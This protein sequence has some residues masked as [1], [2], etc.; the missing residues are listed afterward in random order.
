MIYTVVPLGNP[1]K[2]YEHTRH[3]AA[4]VVL[5]NIADDVRSIDTCEI[6]VP[7]TFMNESGKAIS[8]YLRYHEDRELVVVYDDKD[9]A[10][11]KIRI[12]YDRGD[13]GHNGVRNIIESLGKKD[14]IRIRIGI[15]PVKEDGTVETPHGEIVQKYVLSQ[16]SPDDMNSLRAV[17]SNVLG[18]LKTIA[19]EG[20]Q[21]AMERY[22][23]I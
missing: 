12:S 16:L 1:G 5:S 8:E 4:R 18:A 22:N 10:L 14:F 3:N 11:G 7:V 23:G 13:G 21:K 17:A 19:E 15:A 6:F 20:H 2:E 9:I